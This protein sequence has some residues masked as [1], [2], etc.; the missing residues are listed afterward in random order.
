MFSRLRETIRVFKGNVKEFELKEYELKMRAVKRCII[1][2]LGEAPTFKTVY[3]SS[4]IAAEMQRRPY[5]KGEIGVDTTWELI[6]LKV[7]TDLRKESV[8]YVW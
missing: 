2:D 4:D 6:P 1:R 5:I 8:V 7:D 3:I